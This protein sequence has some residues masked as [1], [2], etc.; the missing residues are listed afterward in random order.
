MISFPPLVRGQTRRGG[1]SLDNKRPGGHS[2][3]GL[4]V[5]L[6]SYTLSSLFRFGK[7]LLNISVVTKATI[8]AA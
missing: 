1:Q 7:I 8:M 3:P 2:P 5:W 4:Y 6:S